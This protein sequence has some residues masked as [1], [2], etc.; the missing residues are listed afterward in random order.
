MHQKIVLPGIIFAVFMILLHALGFYEFFM[1]LS[2]HEGYFIQQ[3]YSSAAMEYFRG[4]PFIFTALWF[5]SLLSG[6]IAPVLFL[7]RNRFVELIAFVAVAS[8]T[9]TLLFT[10]LFR[11]RISALGFT[12]FIFDVALLALLGLFYWYVR[13]M[14]RKWHK[15]AMYVYSEPVRQERHEYNL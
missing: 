1:S 4:F 2:L 10:V 9:L 8:H 3:G 6:M 15:H 13:Q 7:L 14:N 5:L 11:G 12:S